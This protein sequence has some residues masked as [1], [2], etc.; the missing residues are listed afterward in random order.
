[1]FDYLIL[2]LKDGPVKIKLRPDLAPGHVER[3]KTLAAKGFYDGVVFHRVIPGFMV[4]VGDPQSRYAD[5]KSRW[6]TGGPGYRFGDE[7]HPELKHN[8]GGKLSMANADEARALAKLFERNGIVCT[9]SDYWLQAEGPWEAVLD[10]LRG[11]K[12]SNRDAGPSS[13]SE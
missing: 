1:M 11:G 3:I 6:G 4:Q 7:I 9:I 12:P 8:A 13:E 10:V 2:D 5:M